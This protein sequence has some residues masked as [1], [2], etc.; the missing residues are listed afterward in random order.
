[1]PRPDME[2]LRRA[3]TTAI[4]LPYGYT[5]PTCWQLHTWG[6]HIYPISRENRFGLTY[7]DVLRPAVDEV[8]R[9]LKNNVSYDV[10]PA[11]EAFDRTDYEKVIW[12]TEEGR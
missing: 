11:G 5:L 1:H 2:K 7:K 9:C 10:V 12:I 3:A 6:T 8:T 4:V